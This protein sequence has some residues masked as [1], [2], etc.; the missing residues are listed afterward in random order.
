MNPT[1]P[2]EEELWYL[3]LLK[4]MENEGYPTHKLH[5]CISD[6]LFTQIPTKDINDIKK[7]WDKIYTEIKKKEALRS[8]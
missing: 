3:N 5:H 4:K 7:L 2:T 8:P 1:N 6:P